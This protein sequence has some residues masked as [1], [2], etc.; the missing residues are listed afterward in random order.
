MG[1]TLLLAPVHG[2]TRYRYCLPMHNL[3]TPTRRQGCRPTWPHP[4]HLVVDK[5]LVETSHDGDQI[6]VPCSRVFSSLALKCGL[7]SQLSLVWYC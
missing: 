5:V 4:V 7:F 1:S 6:V 2:L 3:R